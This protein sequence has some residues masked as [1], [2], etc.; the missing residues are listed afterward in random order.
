MSKYRI[1]IQKSIP[2]VEAKY[3]RTENVYEQTTDN[4]I[5]LMSIITAFN[6]EPVKPEQK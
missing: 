2:A 4:E 5:D 6:K 3:D 1:I